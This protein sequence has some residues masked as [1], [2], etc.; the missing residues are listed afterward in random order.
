MARPLE[1]TRDV[2]TALDG[3]GAALACAVAFVFGAAGLASCLVGVYLPV[4]ALAGAVK[5]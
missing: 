1:G 3:L 2:F 5:E 4:F